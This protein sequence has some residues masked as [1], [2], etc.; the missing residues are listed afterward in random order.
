MTCQ[1]ARR[2]PAPDLELDRPVHTG[3]RGRYDALVAAVEEHNLTHGPETKA[4]AR[5]VRLARQLGAQVT[6]RPR[7]RYHA[8]GGALHDALM[9]VGA[10]FLPPTG[11]IDDD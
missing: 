6:D 7:A 4:P 9:E 8:E 3:V 2:L 1:I 11:D 10:Q 5:L